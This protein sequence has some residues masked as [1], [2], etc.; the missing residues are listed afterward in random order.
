MAAAS[1]GQVGKAKHD[2]ED[3]EEMDIDAVDAG[4][5]VFEPAQPD[6]ASPPVGLDCPIVGEV[7]HCRE[8]HTL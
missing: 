2:D 8:L 7:L 5:E 1:R 6:L 4:D 3:V